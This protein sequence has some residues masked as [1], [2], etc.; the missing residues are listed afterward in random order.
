MPPA[1][2]RM[3]AEEKKNTILL[4]YHTTKDV[5][6]EKEIISLATKSG[7]SQGAIVD[8]NESLVDDNLVSTKKLGGTKYYWSFPGKKDRDMLTKLTSMQSELES[9]KRKRSSMEASL[10]SARLGREDVEGS[11]LSKLQKITSLR[12]LK[13]EREKELEVLK[14]NDPEVIEGL[15]K[16]F[17]MSKEAANRW[18]DNIFSC[19]SYLT[20]KRGMSSK[21]AD[22][23]LQI[24]SSFDYPEDKLAK[25]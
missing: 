22:G 21:E 1:S 25:A 23:F 11:R 8:T 15:K 3:S 12:A 10:S 24:T 20:K 13:A 6:T 17:Q 14:E 7:V 2:K 4:I 16:E 18:T 5:Y 19:K 9:S